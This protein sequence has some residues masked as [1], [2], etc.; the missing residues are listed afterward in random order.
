[1]YGLVID[2]GVDD[3]RVVDVAMVLDLPADDVTWWS[4]PEPT[5]WFVSFLRLDKVPVRA[6]WR[7]AVW[8][9]WN[10]A[11]VRPLRIWSLDGSVDS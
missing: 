10:H 7:P 9:V 5:R 6:Q 3:L 11:I 1:M 2:P 8:P 4:L